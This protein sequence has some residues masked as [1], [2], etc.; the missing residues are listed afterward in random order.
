MNHS[1][2]LKTIALSSI[3]ALGLM[4][5]GCDKDDIIDAIGDKVAIVNVVNADL[6]PIDV[7]VD[8]ET[9]S[10][11]SRGSAITF[12][13]I[14]RDD[15]VRVSS[16]AFSDFNVKTSDINVVGISSNCASH[17]SL[18]VGD[19]NKIH[20]MNLSGALVDSSDLTIT[21]TPAGSSTSQNVSL[22]AVDICKIGKTFTGST[23]GDWK[24]TFANGQTKTAT[25]TK[26]ISVEVIVYDAVAANGTII[27][28]A[29]LSDL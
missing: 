19:S 10:I 12:S 1:K 21:F 18:D 2:T 7:T 13:D 6:G 11:P 22:A 28:L 17:Y 15:T 26:D 8:G 3:L 29:E 25:L 14:S 23:I 24:I 5:T 9:Q 4:S 20:L 16:S 27:P